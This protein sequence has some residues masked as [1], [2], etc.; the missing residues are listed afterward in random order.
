MSIQVK[1]FGPLIEVVGKSE[2]EMIGIFDSDS[3]RKTILN[4][5]PDLKNF[6]FLISVCRKITMK[7][8]AIK[9]GDEVAVLPPFAGG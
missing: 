7:N 5:F 8:T 3:L 2:I 9:S 6:T 4:D 1:F